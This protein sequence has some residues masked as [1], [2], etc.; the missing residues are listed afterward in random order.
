[1]KT[2]MLVLLLAFSQ[3]LQAKGPHTD[4]KVLD[5]FKKTYPDAQKIIWDTK[6]D[7][8]YVYFEKDGISCRM[9]YD[10]G[11]D[12]VSSDRYYT[13]ERILPP[14][15]LNKIKKEYPAYKIKG[16]TEL[17][18]DGSVRYFPTLENGKRIVKL[19][20]NASGYYAVLDKFEVQQ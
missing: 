17:T 19:E 16:V 10:K 18:N 8:Y 1:M 6:L 2:I 11:G 20:L 7:L 14:V 5:L 4:E 13:D 12:I 3:A 15:V 9:Y